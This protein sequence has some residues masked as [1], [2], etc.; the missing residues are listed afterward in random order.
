[1]GDAA[2]SEERTAALRTQLSY[3]AADIPLVRLK[4]D[5]A[6]WTQFH[7]LPRV[8]AQN[9]SV[10]HALGEGCYPD[11]VVFACAE[12]R[13]ASVE[14][15]TARQTTL[16]PSPLPGVVLWIEYCAAAHV[17][18]VG[19]ASVS[20]GGGSAGKEGPRV[21][22]LRSPG[23][24]AAE[25]TV[26]ATLS[27]IAAVFLSSDGDRFALL[28]KVSEERTVLFS[29]RRGDSLKPVR[30]HLSRQRHDPSPV[31]LSALAS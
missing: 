12:S 4:V 3:A 10:E 2:G 14:L 26:T 25:L 28:E 6:S 22:V 23:G 5:S 13:L 18:L 11:H 24:E 7:P 8:C 27:G 30:Y 21:V 9:V 31:G 29:R 16:T 19:L 17:A 20:T 15:A 1:M